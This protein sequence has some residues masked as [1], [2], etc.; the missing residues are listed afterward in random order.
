MLKVLVTGHLGFIG[1]YLTSELN[2][3]KIGWLGL[4]LKKGEDIRN[5]YKVYEAFDFYRPDAV[6]HLAALAGV[7][8]GEEYPDEYIS[9]N[10]SG[11]RILLKVAE[12]FKVKKFI[13]FSSSSVFGDAKPPVSE[14]DPKNPKSIYG[15]SKLMAE[16]LCELSPLVTITIR[17]FTVYGINGRPDMVIYIWLDQ[18]RR[19]QA[20]DFYGDGTSKR[21]YVHVQDLV[22]GVT[23]LLTDFSGIN[24]STSYNLGGQEIVSLNRLCEIFKKHYKNLKI[25]RL[26]MPSSDI[27]ENWSNI[28]KA[29]KELKWIPERNF[30]RELE[31]I[32]VNY[33]K[34]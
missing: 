15:L 28:S 32:I 22:S 31:R 25:N 17:P 6:I 24:F 3:L 1:S 33:E 30:E 21:G 27:Y 19:G 20:I 18:I 26:P 4:D 5:E 2:K 13:N 11:T 8:R 7:R 10:F 12:K 16:K 9:T 14:D 34:K 29:R 23:S